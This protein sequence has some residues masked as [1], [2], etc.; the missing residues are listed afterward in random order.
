MAYKKEWFN[1]E[2]FWEAYAP[3][4]FD[5]QHWEE[6]SLVADGVTRLA[7]L[8]LYDEKRLQNSGSGTPGPWAL[9]MCCGFGR[10]TLELARRGFTATG[11]DITQSYLQTAQED[12]AYEHLDIEFIHADVRSFRRPHFFDVVTN[13]YIS[14][15][16]FENPDH[17]RLVV[18]NA[19]ESLKPGGAF[20]VETLGKE[21]AVR[22]F[23]DRE[24]FTRAG[25]TILTEYTPVDSWGGLKNRWILLNKGGECLER[26]FTQRLYA[27]TELRRLLLDAGFA[28]VE[29]YGDWNDGV[30]DNRAQ[31]LIAV[32]RKAP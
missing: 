18:Q 6:V 11:V 1:E 16:Y 32:G 13:L 14:F 26:T 12:A 15:G 25:L 30:Y 23:V 5:P 3:I 31:I 8:N 27:A 4:M 9:D 24:W 19:Y 21:I 29:L 28:S 7:Q 17:D 2:R 10:I 22:D 20:I